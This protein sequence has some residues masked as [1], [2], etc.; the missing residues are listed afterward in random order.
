MI[1]GWKYTRDTDLMAWS[2]LAPADLA[3]AWH[4]CPYARW[5]CCAEGLIGWVWRWGTYTANPGAFRQSGLCDPLEHS[6][7]LAEVTR[8][9]DYHRAIGGHFASVLTGNAKEGISR[10]RQKRAVVE[11]LKRAADIVENTELT[12]VVELINKMARPGY[13]LIYSDEAAEVI[14]EVGSQ[15]VRL[16]FDIFHQQISEGNLIT[17]IRKHHR[18][19]GYYQCGDVP[20]RNEPG[21][22]EIN[23]RNVFKAIYE[24]GYRGLVGMEHHISTAGE[25]GLEK[26]FEAYR[27]A[28]SW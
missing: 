5:R 8:T 24:T 6:N 25:A 4:G 28:D 2:T 9:L 23:W 21:T 18:S 14:A 1:G 16:L 7:F 15:H 13:F 12:L 22:G 26:C 19:I 3:A 17:H 27:Q 11:S 10:D 20:G